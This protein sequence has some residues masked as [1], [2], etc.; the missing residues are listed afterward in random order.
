MKHST[1][2]LNEDYQR[3]LNIWS[4]PENT[5]QL[6]NKTTENPKVQ[7][8]QNTKD[9]KKETEFLLSDDMEGYINALPDSELTESES[10]YEGNYCRTSK[11]STSSK[12]IRNIQENS[13][14]RKNRETSGKCYQICVNIIR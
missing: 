5:A 3:I 13:V 10:G 12:S 8:L 14:L 11:P 9:C 7:S 2:D 1:I 6:R 4:P